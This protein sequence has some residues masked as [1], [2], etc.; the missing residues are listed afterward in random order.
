MTEAKS[1]NELKF[2]SVTSR[3]FEMS[4]KGIDAAIQ[5]ARATKRPPD[6]VALRDLR[7]HLVRHML[8]I[9]TSID[10][11]IESAVQETIEMVSGV[12]K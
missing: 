7:A 3:L 4:S 10:S 9:T 5:T 8:A 6:V 11:A 12:E 2:A 1:I